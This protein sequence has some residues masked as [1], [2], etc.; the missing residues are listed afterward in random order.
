MLRLLPVKDPGQLVM[1]WTTGPHFGSNQGTRGVSYPMYQDFERR[2]QVFSYVFCRRYAPMSA[3]FGNETERVMG[4]MVSGNFFQALGVGAVVGR[5]FSPEEDDRVYKG[6]PA[7]V[8]SHQYW[9]TRFGADSGVVGK[10]VLVNNYPMTIV[11]VSAAGF[12]GI[13]PAQSPQI[14]V[15]IQMKPLMTPGSDNLG[16]RRSQWVQMFARL[17]PGYTVAC[18]QAS[19]QPLLG[20]I[21]GDEI[22]QPAL[23]DLAAEPP[24]AVPGP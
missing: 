4:E 21:L 10:K 15:P 9:V 18:A 1:I 2:A 16:N 23:R 11:G 14:R 6:H 5:V 20:Q 13:D 7:V 19:L 3:S 22:Q 24:R 8:L 12:S 17:K